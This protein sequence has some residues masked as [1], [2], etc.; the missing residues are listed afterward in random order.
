M[1]V[2]TIIFCIFIYCLIDRIIEGVTILDEDNKTAYKLRAISALILIAI[3][4]IVS[5]I[6]CK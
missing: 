3:I 6:K 5:L 2:L 4:I 1:I